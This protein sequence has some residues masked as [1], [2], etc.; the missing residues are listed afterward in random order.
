[1]QRERVLLLL[2]AVLLLLLLLRQC[3]GEVLRGKQSR[4]A[5]DSSLCL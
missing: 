5:N 1:M 2:V 3:G 4:A